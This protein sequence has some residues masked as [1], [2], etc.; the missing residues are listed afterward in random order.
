MVEYLGLIY[1]I[2][3]DIKEYFKYV[4]SEKMVDN[5]YV[6]QLKKK[7]ESDGENISFYWSDEDKLEVRKAK[8]WDYYYQVDKN[9]KKK[10]ILKNKTGQI[11]IAKITN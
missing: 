8:G 7:H 10:F 11:L 6:E 4:E 2:I 1:G 3:K 5:S 9:K